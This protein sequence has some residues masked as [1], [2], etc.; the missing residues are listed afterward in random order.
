[1]LDTSLLMLGTSVFTSKIKKNPSQFFSMMF[2]ISTFLGQ[3]GVAGL[4]ML[5]HPPFQTIIVVIHHNKFHQDIS[6]CSIV[7]VH[8]SKPK[9]SH[10]WYQRW[11]IFCENY[12]KNAPIYKLIIEIVVTTT[13]HRST[14]HGSQ[15]ESTYDMKL[16]LHTNVY[17]CKFILAVF[18]KRY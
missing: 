9:I 1:M 3:V 18:I 4:V 8:I 16:S 11:P 7:I 5:P 14:V 2:E 15:Q 17:L 10:L 12:L 13:I 6:I